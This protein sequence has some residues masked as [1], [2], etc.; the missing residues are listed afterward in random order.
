MWAYSM[1]FYFFNVRYIN[2]T[3]NKQT[4]LN[5]KVLKNI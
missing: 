4:V 2:Y 5:F 3:H 1:D